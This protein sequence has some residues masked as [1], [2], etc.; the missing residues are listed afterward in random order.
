MTEG[1]DVTKQTDTNIDR[2]ME[3]QTDTDR[4]RY[5]Q[6]DRYRKTQTKTDKDRH[7][8]IPTYADKDKDRHRQT[9]TD[10][11]RQRQTQTYTA[12]RR[13]THTHTTNESQ[14]RKVEHR[15]NS[16]VCSI[17]HSLRPFILRPV[18]YILILVFIRTLMVSFSVGLCEDSNEN[19]T[20]L[21]AE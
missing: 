14:C 20:T 13:K 15:F 18:K 10:T 2:H 6:T 11:D 4:H 19:W 3:T 7:S 8:Q 1:R 16:F 21:P 9:K 12:R 5:T 17:I